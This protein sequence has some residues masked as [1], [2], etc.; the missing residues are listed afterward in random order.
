MTK[1]TNDQE[2]FKRRRKRRG[3]R[4]GRGREKHRVS[5]KPG[6]DDSGFHLI[7]VRARSWRHRSVRKHESV[8][9]SRRTLGSLFKQL[10]RPLGAFLLFTV[11][12]WG[13]WECKFLV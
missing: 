12:T 5:L 7:F 1:A 4:E 13:L 11:R 2:V 3:E 6:N 8:P 10:V 9:G